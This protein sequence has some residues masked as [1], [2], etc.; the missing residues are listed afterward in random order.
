[1]GIKDIAKLA[2]VSIGTVDRV[3][4]KRSGVSKKTEERVLKIIKDTGYKTNTTASRLKLASVKKIVI[5]ILIPETKNKWDYWRLPK[6]GITK[7]VEEIKELGV[8]AE[9]YPFSDSTTFLSQSEKI[10]SKKYSAI[11]TVP[12]FKNASNSL[13]NNAKTKNIPVVFL[14]TEI[15]LESSAYFIRQ[16][17][18]NAGKV[19]GRLLHGLVGDDGQYFIINIINDEGIHANNMQRE[20][21]FRTFFKEINK[22]V[23][24]YTINYSIKKD[25]FKIT[26][27]MAKWFAEDNK[28]GIFVTNSRTHIIPKILKDNKI[29][30]AHIIGFDLN[31]KNVALIQENKIDFLIN[32]QP[33]YQGYI[34]IK[35][36]FNFLTRQDDSELNIDIPVEI[37]VK[38]NS[39]ELKM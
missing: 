5:A 37:I 9:F 15:S 24:I 28:K 12:F 7:A 30:N 26:D 34:A 10:I 3:L 11:V 29:K 31:K 1:M 22:K 27:E 33:K 13:L 25:R 21:G 32:Q 17:S 19:A 2:N 39:G 14:D 38:E 4:H 36:I 20:D 6:K 16:N 8:E 35:S 18:K 23:K